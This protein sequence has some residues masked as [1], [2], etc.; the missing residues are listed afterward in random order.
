M[1]LIIRQ[2]MSLVIVLVVAKQH[3]IFVSCRAAFESGVKLD[4]TGLIQVRVASYLY[5]MLVL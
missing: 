4:G 3:T 5:N 2:C 1:W